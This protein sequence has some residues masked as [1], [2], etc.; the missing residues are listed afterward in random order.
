MHFED[1]AFTNGLRNRLLQS[2]P[3]AIPIP[4][5][6]EGAP[7]D[8]DVSGTQAEGHEEREIES[9]GCSY[10]SITVLALLHKYQ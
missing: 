1:R 3:F 2:H 5:D 7:S 4:W 9:V 6:E 10:I 8:P